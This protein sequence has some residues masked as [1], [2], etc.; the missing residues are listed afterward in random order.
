MNLSE[1]ANWYNQYAVALAG[2]ARPSRRVTRA[3]G[4]V[5]MHDMMEMTAKGQDKFGNAFRG[6]STKPIYIS[7]EYLSLAKT[8][9]GRTSYKV[10]GRKR[11][12]GKT[13][14]GGKPQRTSQM[15]TVEFDGGYKQFKE[16]LGHSTVD[17]TVTG[18]M[19]GSI[20]LKITGDNSGE[21]DFVDPDAARRA[22]GVID[23]GRDFWGVLLTDDGLARATQAGR[24]EYVLQLDGAVPGSEIRSD[25]EEIPF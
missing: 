9:G 5:A 18:K 23:S 21:I 6:Y 16:G 12:T 19:L 1:A 7:G 2:V 20:A 14:K 13:T 22:G 8:A 17:L 4:N 10:E 25:D 15:K 24:N 3:I 11:E